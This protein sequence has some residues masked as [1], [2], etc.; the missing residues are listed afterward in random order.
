MLFNQYADGS[1]F[2]LQVNLYA[3]DQHSSDH[4]V[5]TEKEMHAKVHR[6]ADKGSVWTLDIEDQAL[7]CDDGN[8]SIDCNLKA[9]VDTTVWEYWNPTIRVG[10]SR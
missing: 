6:Y 3:I 5:M 8:G 10:W 1:K 4:L 2:I 7:T 9:E